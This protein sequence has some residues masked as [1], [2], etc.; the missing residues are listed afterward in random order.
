MQ[1]YSEFCPT[2]FD[3]H[4]TLDSIEDW[5]IVPCSRNRDSECLDESNFHSA[6]EMLGGEGDDVQLHRFGHWASGW[7][8]LIL[9]RPN[10]AA[11]KEAEEIETS[12][13]Q[14]P[15]LN[16]DDFSE[17]EQVAAN[18]TWRQC[19]SNAKRIEYIRRYRSQFEFRGFADLLGC[20][21]GNYF[22]GYASELLNR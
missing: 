16:D 14:Y 3:S 1:S 8:E 6:L 15:V 10:T 22:G 5:L 17:R 18:L 13:A 19:Y 4:I 9:V 2:G 7:F 11:A 21:R 20:V 12:L